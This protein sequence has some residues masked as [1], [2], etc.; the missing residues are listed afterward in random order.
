MDDDRLASLE[1][2]VQK[3]E[4]ELAILRLLHSYGP[5]VD[6]GSTVEAAA[7]WTEGGTYEFSDGDEVARLEAPLD[8]EK[9]YSSDF[10]QS[11]IATGSAHL[12]GPPVMTI[13]GDRAQAVAYSFVVV[14]DGDR[15]LVLRAAINHWSLIRS[16][17]GWRVERR[18]NRVLNGS[19]ESRRLM[20]K[21]AD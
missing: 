10:H 5:L 9:L 2:R 6:S 3:V 15:W 8:L 12:T 18:R 13:D 14:R 17:V 4:D 1:T 21:V 20:R 19:E 16:S 7:L 11:L